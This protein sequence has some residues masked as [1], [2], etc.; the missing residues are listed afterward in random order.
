MT[1][2]R[3]ES[4]E[5]MP[6]YEFENDSSLWRSH[7]QQKHHAHYCSACYPLRACS[8]NSRQLVATGV[9]IGSSNDQLPAIR[10]GHKGG[11]Q[12]PYGL[13]ARASCACNVTDMRSHRTKVRP[14][15]PSIHLAFKYLC[16]SPPCPAPSSL[17]DPLNRCL[18]SFSSA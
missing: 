7:L 5:T 10:V 1:I 4:T 8:I 13:A 15:M 16:L 14:S 12:V 18:T 2:P 11:L 3:Q 6:F 17:C 9:E